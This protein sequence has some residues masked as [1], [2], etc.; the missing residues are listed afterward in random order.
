M[1]RMGKYWTCLTSCYSA[2]WQHNHLISFSYILQVPCRYISYRYSCAKNSELF[3]FSLNGVPF[4]GLKLLTS[5]IF[6]LTDTDQARCKDH[7]AGG[8]FPTFCQQL[9]MP[10]DINF[11]RRTWK[12]DGEWPPGQRIFFSWYR[13]GVLKFYFLRIDDS[14]TFLCVYNI[15]IDTYIYIHIYPKEEAKP[16]TNFSLTSFEEPGYLVS[17]LCWS[18]YMVSLRNWRTVCN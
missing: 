3:E 18:C 5:T 14:C 12:K 11:L 10:F 8:P 9:C 6:L 13:T 17:Y 7:Q 15:Y 4:C 1:G 16:F 2:V